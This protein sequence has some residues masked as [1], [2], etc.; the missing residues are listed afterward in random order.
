MFPE[1]VGTKDYRK[2][3]WVSHMEEMQEAL[4]GKEKFQLSSINYV[5]IRVKKIKTRITSP[6]K[7]QIIN[8]QKKFYWEHLY[9]HYLEI[10]FC[11]FLERFSLY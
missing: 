11:I 8:I 2:P 5:L 10:L 1:I 4:K 3:E 7:N 9:N 6:S